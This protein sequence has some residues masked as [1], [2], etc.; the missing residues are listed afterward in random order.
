MA[1]IGAAFKGVGKA[2]KKFKTR[3]GPKP[4]PENKFKY[5]GRDPT[6]ENKFDFI[7]RVAAKEAHEAGEKPPFKIGKLA[8]RIVQTGVGAPIA[9]IGASKVKK[10]LSKHHSKKDK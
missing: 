3:H 1:G 8:K 10:K 6:K 2:Y 7:D 4:G 5:Q 9:I